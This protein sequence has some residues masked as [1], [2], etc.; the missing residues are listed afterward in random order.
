PLNVLS[1]PLTIHSSTPPT[2]FYRDGYCDFAAADVEKQ[3]VAA[4]LTPEFLDFAKKKKGYD[5]RDVYGKETIDEVM[6][7]G[8]RWC[9][10][11]ENWWSTFYEWKWGLIGRETVPKVDLEATHQMAL[12]IAEWEGLWEFRN[13]DIEAI[14]DVELGGIEEVDSEKTH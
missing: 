2:G 7:S 12:K 14:R 11:V 1:S 13:S 4:I 6:S 9:I 3:W 8:C 10:S 5:Y